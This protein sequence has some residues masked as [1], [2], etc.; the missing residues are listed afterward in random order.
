MIGLLLI[1]G[2]IFAAGFGCGYATRANISHRRRRR[3]RRIW[4]EGDQ[5]DA[6][7]IIRSIA[8]DEEARREATDA[9]RGTLKR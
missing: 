4:R 3:S 9:P 7:P 5:D 1:I 8:H 2:M 6:A